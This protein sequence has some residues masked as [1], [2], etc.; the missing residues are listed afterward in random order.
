VIGLDTN[1]LVRYIVQ[2]EVHQ[3]AVATRLIEGFTPEAPGFVSTV[4]LVETV[5]VLTVAYKTPKRDVATVIEG[6]LRA[7]EVIVENADIHYLALGAFQRAAVDYADAVI[8]QAGR[9]S[10]CDHTV[11]FD[12]RAGASLLKLLDA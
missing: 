2:D 1:V 9:Q 3:A 7:R 8:A 11:T 12:R 10:G 4:T 6:L 5:W